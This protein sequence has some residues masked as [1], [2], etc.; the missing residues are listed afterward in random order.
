ME[1]A[2]PSHHYQG[3]DNRVS[4]LP[5]YHCSDGGLV[6]SAASLRM[7]DQTVTDNFLAIERYVRRRLAQRPITSRIGM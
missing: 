5:R 1:G 4:S 2:W 7:T 6:W 3:D